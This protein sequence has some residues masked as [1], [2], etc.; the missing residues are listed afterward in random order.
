LGRRFMGAAVVTTFLV[1]HIIQMIHI[2]LQLRICC[3]C[4][5]YETTQGSKLSALTLG[6]SVILSLRLLW[7]ASSRQALASSGRHRSLKP[8]SSQCKVASTTGSPPSSTCRDAGT[9]RAGCRAVSRSCSRTGPERSMSACPSP[10]DRGGA[11]SAAAV[12]CTSPSGST[13]S[14]PSTCWRTAAGSSRP[15]RW[16]R[17]SCRRAL[18]VVLLLLAVYGPRGSVADTHVSDVFIDH[19]AAGGRPQKS[20]FLLLN[21]LGPLSAVGHNLVNQLDGGLPFFV[22]AENHISGMWTLPQ[23]WRDVLG[24]VFLACLWDL[25]ADVPSIAPIVPSVHGLSRSTDRRDST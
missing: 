19:F 14:T 11:S 21:A 24:R 18:C 9:T 10:S 8:K 16:A 2:F 25:A 6:S 7:L 20:D 13:T 23:R 5:G 12:P 22:K 1:V 3:L 4:G 15:S 17:R